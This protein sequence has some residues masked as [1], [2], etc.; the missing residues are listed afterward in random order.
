LGKSD[1][2][3][4]V[5]IV[6]RIVVNNDMRAGESAKSQRRD[7]FAGA[8]CHR[9]PHDATGALQTA[10]NFGGLVGSDAPR[11]AEGN[12]SARKRTAFGFICHEC[13]PQ[14]ALRFSENV[15]PLSRDTQRA[16]A[17]ATLK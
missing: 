9:D 10:Q 15:T 14:S 3:D 5:W 12:F 2:R 8:P 17:R 7:E 13:L 11:N 4:R 16:F 6:R 1:V